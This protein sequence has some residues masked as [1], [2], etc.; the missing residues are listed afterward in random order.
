MELKDYKTLTLD[1]LMGL[2]QTK[3]PKIIKTGFRYI[4]DVVY[5]LMQKGIHLFA[6]GSGSGKSYILMQIAASLLKQG[7]DILYISLENNIYKDQERLRDAFNK[8]PTQGFE[9]P[10]KLE[11]LTIKY[12]EGI[13]EGY[14]KS[15]MID[16]IKLL[17]HKVEADRANK[18]ELPHRFIF[19]DA[20]E[21]I[22]D[23]DTG[24]GMH[25]EG[26]AFMETLVNICNKGNYTICLSWQL[27]SSAASL[28]PSNITLGNLT[29]SSSV[30]HMCSNSFAI[31]RCKRDEKIVYV[32]KLLKP[33]DGYNENFDNV[34]EPMCIT[35]DI[36]NKFDYDYYTTYVED[37]K[38]R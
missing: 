38:R 34:F 32:M 23:G 28:S 3:K 2:D 18:V 29:F 13:S 14:S 30:A 6:G 1:E 5:G 15:Q 36:T 20:P 9:E 24:T 4:D 27:N 21:I 17:N 33:R 35:N 26:K 37:N 8:A 19:I 12:V 25:S 16:Y 31:V 10:G 11:Y 22:L 7:N